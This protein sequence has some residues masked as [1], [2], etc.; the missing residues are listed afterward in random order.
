MPAA[1][2]QSPNQDKYAH[3]SRNH[4]II[5]ALETANGFAAWERALAS[6]FGQMNQG[7]LSEPG[8]RIANVRNVGGGRHQP[9]Q[10]RKRQLATNLTPFI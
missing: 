8:K 2:E 1:Q 9:P 10:D 5:P 7:R 4:S 3:G 6:I